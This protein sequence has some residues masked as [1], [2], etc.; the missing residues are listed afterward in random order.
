CLPSARIA[1]RCSGLKL[2]PASPWAAAAGKRSGMKSA[3][4]GSGAAFMSLLRCPV[5]MGCSE[6]SDRFERAV[7]AARQVDAGA[8]AT[9]D[10]LP[11]VALEIG[12]RGALAGR[13]GTCGAVVLTFQRNA[14]ALLL[15]RG[16]GGIGF[17]LGQGTG[18]GNG[19]E[20]GRDGAGEDER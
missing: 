5:V 13:A 1:A 8:G 9:L 3:G 11:G 16:D 7:F 10:E 6:P 15:V 4:A 12:C 14:E 17:G 18:G 19:R 20:R 2:V